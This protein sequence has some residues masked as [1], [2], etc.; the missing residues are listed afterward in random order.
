MTVHPIPPGLFCVPSALCALTGQ[1]PTAVIVPAINRHD[2]NA[3]LTDNVAGVHLTAA[4]AVL[5]ELGYAVR[6]YRHGDL[7]ARVST[8]A[9]RS[10]RYPGRPLLL[11][12]TGGRRS[13]GHALVV[14]D[15]KIYDNHLP[16]GAAPRAHPFSNCLVDYA[17]LVEKRT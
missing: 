11:A 3:S 14:A 10:L 12:T 5:A 15:G 17:V 2:R 13:P 4:E 9:E 6:K 8:W 16:A 7:R 1:H